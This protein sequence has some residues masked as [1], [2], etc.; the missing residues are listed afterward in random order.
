MVFLV[1]LV[2]SVWVFLVFLVLVFLIFL[3]LVFWLCQGKGVVLF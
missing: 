2:F 3:V 1:F